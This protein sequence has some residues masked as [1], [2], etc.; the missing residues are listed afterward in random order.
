MLSLFIQGDDDCG[1]IELKWKPANILR[2]S[3]TTTVQ[4]VKTHQKFV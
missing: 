1:A 3:Q 2:R 4:I